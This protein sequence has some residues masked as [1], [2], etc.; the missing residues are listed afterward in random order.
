MVLTMSLKIAL[1]I[2]CGPTINVSISMLPK[3][4]IGIKSINIVFILPIG[5][6]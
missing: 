6:T 2:A 3:V 4:C 1:A 5:I